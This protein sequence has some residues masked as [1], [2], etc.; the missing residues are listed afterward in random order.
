MQKHFSDGVAELPVLAGPIP[1]ESPL[2]FFQYIHT[3]RD[4]AIAA[5]HEDVYLKPIVEMKHWRLSAFIV[6]DPAGIKHVL[7][8]NADNYVKGLMENRVL[9]VWAREG[10]EANGEN[11][12]RQRRAVMSPHFDHRS[13]H[14]HSA[15]ILDAAQRVV[16]RWTGLAEGTIL[17]MAEEMSGLTL[18]IVCRIVFSSDFAEFARIMES[19]SRRYQAE[20]S[21]DLLDF[22]PL[23]D[24]PWGF[25]KRRRHA[26][27]LR[28]LSDAVYRLMARRTEKGALECGDLLNRLLREKDLQTGA[29]LSADEVRS[30]VTTIL[31]AGHE[32]AALALMW[33]WYLLALHPRHE[34]K[35]HAELD[36]V[37]AGRQPALE[38]LTQL[39]YTRMVIEEALRLYPPFHTMAWRVAL[40]DDEV[41]GERVPR[42]ATVSIVP[43]VLHRHRSLWDHP[44]QF[45][46]ERFSPEQ[47]QGRSRFAYLPFGLG[48][49]VCIGASFAMTE[50]MMILATLAQSY[51]VRLV[52][53]HKVEP[54][55]LISLKARYGL[56]ATL[57]RRHR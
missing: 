45:D 18:E 40:A 31:G 46:P 54:Q 43:W 13:F 5:F 29:G 57:E 39:T 47:R 50:M 8:D 34:A 55:G 2:P 37:L 17:E 32:T 21:L 9:P 49:R 26:G 44:D 35:L 15:V 1:P 30:Q 7:I 36:R 48:P 42:G 3:M 11:S 33:V 25:Y 24:L 6:N 23:L 19:A 16:D 27:I 4:N 38:D 22:V 28:G 53:E 10:P 12:A 52:P 41:C 14:E 20:P 56:K 51:R